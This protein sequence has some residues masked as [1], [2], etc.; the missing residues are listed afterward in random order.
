MT[1]NYIWYEIYIYGTDLMSIPTND[2]PENNKK[3]FTY[4][5]LS[6]PK[7][8]GDEIDILIDKFGYWPSRSAFTR[9]A[10]LEQIHKEKR[11]LN[12]NSRDEIE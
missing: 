8:I 7:A 9:E 1:V 2:K 10:Y 11:K 12:S 5:T 3:D 6:V 4:I